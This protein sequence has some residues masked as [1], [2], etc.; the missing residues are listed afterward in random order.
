MPEDVPKP[1]A[2][3]D[4]DTNPPPAPAPPAP[5]EDAACD[6]L[7]ELEE[8]DDEPVAPLDDSEL[9]RVTSEEQPKSKIAMNERARTCISVTLSSLTFV[10][11]TSFLNALKPGRVRMLRRSAFVMMPFALLVSAVGVGVGACSASG[12]SSS[13]SGFGGSGASGSSGTPSGPSG[14]SGLGGMFGAGG[15]GSGGGMQSSCKVTDTNGNGAPQCT[16][17]SPPNAFSPVVKWTFDGPPPGANSQYTGSF[18]V[19]LVGNFTDDNHDG[20]IDLCDVPD[21]IVQVLSSFG[22]GMGVQQIQANAGLYMLAGDTGALEVTFDG[23]TDALVYP[24]FGDI[25]GDGIPDVLAADPQGHLVAYDNKGHLKWTGDMG[26]Y[27]TGFSSG[28][29]TTIAIYDLDGDGNPEILFGWEVFNNKGKKLFG[30][31]TNASEFEGQYWCVTPTA[32]DLD[33]DGKLEV[34]MGHEA[35]RADGSLYYKLPGFKPAH[36]QVANFDGSGQPEIFLTNPDGITILDHTG[37]IKF[38]P[39]RP[40]GDPPAANCWGKPA[41]VHDFDGD[42]KADIASATCNNYSV[43]TVGATGLTPKWTNPMVQDISGLATATAFDFLGSGSAQAIYADETQV[44]A[45]DGKTGNPVFKAPRQSG[46]LIEYPVV[47]DVDND[48]SAEIVYVSNFIGGMQMPGQHAITVLKDAQ[49]RWIPARRIW[50]QYSYHV[51]NVRE[52]GTIPKKQKNNWQ[53]LNTFRTNS[54]ISAD[55]DCNPNPPPK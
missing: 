6:E 45:M 19:P 15:A 7:D 10:A 23:Q 38:G 48:G 35:F 13:S 39:V 14:S 30:D 29:C 28:E 54:Q 43:Y 2:P 12:K 31:P 20:A 53:N 18:G 25:D 11:P 4:E 52:D 5:D 26:G 44:W 8:V 36:P 9:A 17:K 50:N 37:A 32:A 33:G 1:P 3:E 16:K 41:V 46:T 51:T 55:G 27:R 34:I 42:G 24:A 40:T 49:S 21:V 47:A 22:V